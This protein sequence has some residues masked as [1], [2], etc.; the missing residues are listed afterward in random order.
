MNVSEYDIRNVMD[1]NSFYGGF[2]AALSGKPVWVMNV[3]PPSLRNTLPAI[4]D[5]GLIGSFHDWSVALVSCSM[6]QDSNNH[7]RFL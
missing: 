5:R 1:M 4:Y 3:I 7:F 2:A 6:N